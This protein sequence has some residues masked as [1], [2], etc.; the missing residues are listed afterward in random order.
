MNIKDL[1]WKIIHEADDEN[2]NPSLWSTIINHTITA[3]TRHREMYLKL[4]AV[5][6]RTV[7]GTSQIAVK[8]IGAR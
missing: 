8:S 3:N 6:T 2:G 7:C 5:L 1:T 4:S